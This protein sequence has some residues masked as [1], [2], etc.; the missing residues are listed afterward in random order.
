MKRLLAV[1]LSFAMIFSLS[2]P[3]FAVSND[4][5]GIAPVPSSSLI[6]RDTL[7]LDHGTMY[8][9]ETATYRIVFVVYDTGNVSYSV[10]YKNNPGVVHSG[11]SSVIDLDSNISF[12]VRSID[13]I[14]P[15]YADKLLELDVD[16]TID[17]ASRPTPRNTVLT[18]D[19]AFDFVSKW[20]PGWKT[21]VTSNLLGTYYGSMTVKVYEHVNG[22]VTRDNIVNYYIGDTLSSIAALVF[23][24]N[25]TKI[26]NIV[27]NGFNLIRG[28][29]AQENGTLT[30]FT[31]DNT[32]TK[33]ARINGQTYYWAGWDRNYCV[34][35]GDKATFTEVIYNL[36]H[37]DYEY[38]NAYFGEKAIYNYN[39]GY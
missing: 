3:A 27:T 37:S 5:T 29:I 18:E 7:V 24:L 31:I 33:T 20:G 22:T 4:L 17:F 1:V 38:D 30:Y 9:E 34:Y 39:N 12:N 28:Y 19:D 25:L 15:D 2:V 23:G 21:P 6:M 26:K 10:C 16:E 32:R 13:N 36:A 8:L 35:S 14:F 11:E